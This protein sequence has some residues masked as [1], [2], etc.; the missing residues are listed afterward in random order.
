[1]RYCG[2]TPRRLAFP[3]EFKELFEELLESVKQA[4]AIEK[5]ELKPSRVFRVN[6][7]T[8]VVRVRSKLGLLG[9]KID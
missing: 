6:P 9:G 7:Q 8:E 1:M 2:T 4:K 5:G 3:V